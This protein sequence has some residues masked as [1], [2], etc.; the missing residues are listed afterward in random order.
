MNAE[1]SANEQKNNEVLKNTDIVKRLQDNAAEL[2]A[3]FRSISDSIKSTYGTETFS[4]ITKNIALY[5][6][7]LDG[8]SKNIISLGQL[9]LG[10]LALKEM[11]VLRPLMDGFNKV[12]PIDITLLRSLEL[13]KIPDTGAIRHKQIIEIFS[14][15]LE[16]QNEII[17]LYNSMLAEFRKSSGDQSLVKGWTL[18]IKNLTNQIRWLTVV[19]LIFAVISTIHLFFRR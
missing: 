16:K 5:K 1:S 9:N 8:L 11:G 19:M 12:K 15:N 7:N 10:D 4:N 18:E 13:T 17:E 2:S 6:N 3:K 14:Q